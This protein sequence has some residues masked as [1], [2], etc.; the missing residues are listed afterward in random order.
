MN[1]VAPLV[2]FQAVYPLLKEIEG[3]KPKFI[4]TGSAMG[5]IG[6]MD[7]RAA[8]PSFGYG[9]SKALAHYTVRKI[10]FTYEGII[11]FALDPG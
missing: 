3:K 6:G 9:A 8:Y 11:A 2:L 4:V 7:Q 1:G 10:H 5:S